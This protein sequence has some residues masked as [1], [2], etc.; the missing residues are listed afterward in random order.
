MRLLIGNYNLVKN[1]SQQLAEEIIEY[2]IKHISLDDKTFISKILLV[3]NSSALEHISDMYQKLFK[4]IGISEI[5]AKK[6]RSYV[7]DHTKADVP[8]EAVADI[9]A[10][11]L[12]KCINTVGFEY[13]DESEISDL[14]QANISNDLGL[15]IDVDTENTYNSIE[16]LF[17]NIENRSK[18]LNEEPNKLQLL[19]NYRNYFAWKNRLKV[20]FVSVCDIPNYDITVNDNL[21]KVIEKC[22]TINYI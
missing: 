14:K 19:P 6:I 8:Y 7:D 2:W 17:Y 1:N 20:G 11:I 21:G 4:K 13:L 22:E 16:D 3:D 10:E 9:S 12:N 5:I 15:I 18:I